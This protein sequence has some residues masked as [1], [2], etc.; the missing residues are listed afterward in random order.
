M[1]EVA[2][3]VATEFS[4]ELKSYTK[5]IEDNIKKGNSE[6]FK[7]LYEERTNFILDQLQGTF[8]QELEDI[9]KEENKKIEKM[10]EKEM[11]SVADRIVESRR[12]E[13]R[14]RTYAM[15]D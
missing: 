11:K 2:I 5:K 7:E 8:F 15:Y 10:L 3:L 6:K 12:E 13:Y 9:V 1:K 4:Q 14:R